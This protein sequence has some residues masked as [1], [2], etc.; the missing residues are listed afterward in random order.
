[1]GVLSSSSRFPLTRRTASFTVFDYNRK[2]RK[3]YYTTNT[4]NAQTISALSNSTATSSRLLPPTLVASRP[5]TPSEKTQI[6]STTGL[7]IEAQIADGGAYGL[8][9]RLNGEIRSSG[10]AEMASLVRDKASA[11]RYSLICVA[12]G[13]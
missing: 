3:S 4:A 7:D 12:P 8:D 10:E 11:V 6:H 9:H 13:D 1:M 5:S 2:P